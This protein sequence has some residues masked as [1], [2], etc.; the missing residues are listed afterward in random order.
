MST[1]ASDVTWLDG[2]LKETDR[3]RERKYWELGLVGM[4]T[5]FGLGNREDTGELREHTKKMN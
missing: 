3:Y 1:I 5:K 2:C 4:C